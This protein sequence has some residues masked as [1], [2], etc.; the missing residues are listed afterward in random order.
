MG[1]FDH[2][3]AR[4]AAKQKIQQDYEDKLERSKTEKVRLEKGDLPALLIAALFN[5]VLPI[6]L[7]LTVICLIAY[8]FF[9]RLR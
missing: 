1:F 4:R 8:Y 3:Q 6:M 9:V 7:V 5:F 2:G